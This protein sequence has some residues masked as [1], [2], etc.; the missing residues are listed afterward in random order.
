M[1]ESFLLRLIQLF[2]I[3]SRFHQERKR[4]NRIVRQFLEDQLSIQNPEKYLQNFEDYHDDNMRAG[5]RKVNAMNDERFSVR[6]S[7]RMVRLCS[8][9]NEELNLNQKINVVVVLISLLEA[10]GE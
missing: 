4:V 5:N 10:D 1:S 8:E 3:A 7:S 2:S 9:L 6:E